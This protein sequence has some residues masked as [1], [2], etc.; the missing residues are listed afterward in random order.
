MGISAWRRAPAV[1]VMGEVVRASP[2]SAAALV[3]VVA[4]AAALPAG[5]VLTFGALVGTLLGGAQAGVATGPVLVL[6][7]LFLLTQLAAPVVQVLAENA[8]RLV[9]RA[10][11]A[12]VLD[13]LNRPTGI[14]HLEDPKVPGLM[15]GVNGGLVGGGCRDAVVGLANLAVARG[16]PFLGA[17]VLFAYRWW[18]AALLLA[19]YGYAMVR[20]SRGY[21]RALRSAEGAPDRLR[22]ALYLRDLLCGAS[23]GKEVRTFGLADWLMGRYGEELRAAMADIR[24]GRTGIGRATI[25]GGAAVLATTALTFVLLAADMA[26]GRLAVGEF[27]VFA[28]AATG[29][30]GLASVTPDLLN[31]AVGGATVLAV[32]DLE[33]LLPDRPGGA[34]TVPEFRDRIVFERVS[35]RYPGSDTWVLRDLDLTIRAGES[36]AVAGVNG[37]G[38]T[39]LAKLLCGLYEPTRGRILV[40]GAELRAGDRTGWQRNVAALFQDWVRW[41]LPVRENVALGAPELPSD[42]AALAAVARGAGLTEVVEDLPGGWDTVLSREF[43]GV[44]LS[45]GQWQRVGLARALWAL[46]ASG[47]V[48]VLDEPTAA[49]DVRG[50]LELFDR[51]LKAASG[52]TI[53][54]IS[55]RFSTVRRCDRIVVL[56]EGRVLETGCHD[57]LMATG[58]SY[59]RM[60]ATQADRFTVDVEG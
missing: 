30:V 5:L 60:F 55:H 20:L 29:L 59:W 50:E 47:G 42:D 57:E 12:R 51:V 45:G 18:L 17:T 14:G 24:G 39:T 56:D 58:G 34:V 28:L 44:D 46:R 4:V 1:V 52:R 54:L 25:T 48:L 9:T 36:L 22:R 19:A 6:G 8:G 27:A 31:V 41:A 21:Q 26:G 37:A 53:V 33:R 49:L 38:K 3:A 16:G 7:V 32:R 10:V 40:D 11:S 23:A 43:G 13:A 35:F 15:S 2:W